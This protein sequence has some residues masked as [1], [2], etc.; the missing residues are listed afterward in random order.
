M[1]DSQDRF[2]ND[3]AGGQRNEL[4]LAERGTFFLENIHLR[5][6]ADAVTQG[7]R[8]WE[9]HCQS[10]KNAQTCHW[11]STEERANRT[12]HD[13][14]IE[15]YISALNGVDDTHQRAGLWCW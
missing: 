5:Q 9:L 8:E 13:I 11:R 7:D 15:R 6:A 2:S 3:K 10:D 4:M 12:A 1:T 14:F